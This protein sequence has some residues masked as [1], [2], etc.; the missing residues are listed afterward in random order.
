MGI[1]QLRRAQSLIKAWSRLRY[2]SIPHFLMLP[3]PASL[4]TGVW[5]DCKQATFFLHQD[6]VQ[7]AQALFP[8]PVSYA[9]FPQTDV[10]KRC[11]QATFFLHQDGMERP[12]VQL[13]S[14]LPPLPRS[15]PFPP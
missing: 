2:P 14:L 15:S 11:K 12:Q 10:Q 1:I 7:Q 5:K 3:S 13:I 4:Q 6:G 9:A 8:S